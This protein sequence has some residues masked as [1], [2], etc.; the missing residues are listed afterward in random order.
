[1]FKHDV[2]AASQSEHVDPKSLLEA[3]ST[4]SRTIQ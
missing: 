3:A 4:L 2:P 1:M